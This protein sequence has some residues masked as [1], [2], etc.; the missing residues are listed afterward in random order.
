MGEGGGWDEEGGRERSKREKIEVEKQMKRGTKP[1]GRG[2]D[3]R[4]GRT[5][6]RRFSRRNVVTG[7]VLTA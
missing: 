2:R 1:N 3:K 7:T 4:D 6:A 5:N